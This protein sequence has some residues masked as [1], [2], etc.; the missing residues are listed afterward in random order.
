MR[1]RSRVV[2]A[3][4]LCVAVWSMAL[5]VA[6]A[7]AVAV[8]VPG[9][10][11]WRDWVFTSDVF[12]DEEAVAVAVAPG[13]YPV[14]VGTSVGAPGGDTDIRYVSYEATTPVWRWNAVPLTWDGPAGG[15][16]RPAGVVT[17]AGGD[18]Y[19][20][21]TTTVV[22]G[23]TDIVVL[24]LLGA[25]PTG[26]LS[27]DLL[28]ARQ[29]DGAAGANDEAQAIAAD[30]SGNIYVTGGSENARGD[31]DVVTVKYRPDGTRAWVRRLDSPSKLADRGLAIAVRGASVYV[32]GV[33]R[34]S[35]RADDIVLA[36]Y[37]TAGSRTWVRYY[38]DPQHRSDTVAGIA[39][40]GTS[41]YLCGAGKVGATAPGDALLLKYDAKGAR[42]WARFAGSKGGD[43][44]W[45]DV[46][47]DGKG[48]VHVTGT[49][50]R[51]AT[52]DDI[53]T[54]VYRSNGSLQWGAYFSSAGS[55]ADTGR[56]LAVDASR[57]TYVCGSIAGAA[58]DGDM[59][60]LCYGPT[61]ARAWF[62]R[63][64]DPAAYLTEVNWGDDRAN[65]IALVAGAA[66]IAG[67]STVYHPLSGGG[68][69]GTT[70]DFITL[71]L[72]R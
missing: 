16:D 6:A 40:S 5:T 3:A 48:R 9:H 55:R 2:F 28:W 31:S 29:F 57:R 17:D 35:G 69:G 1:R 12:E 52:A 21:G 46:A 39:C 67:A 58:G 47:V 42:A 18:A 37:T 49:F 26:P 54:R 30:S 19:V 22:G 50:F 11:L 38:D 59:A 32:A 65:D 13:G 60:A 8:T 51:K 72:E 61:G 24:K 25:D 7:V 70:L 20:A 45:G 4:I 33:S 71:K 66:Y 10:H 64:P 44:A 36:R 68:Y 63:C 14:V 56:A 53:S 41:V 27:G 62:S 34:R 43:D 15:D 23:T